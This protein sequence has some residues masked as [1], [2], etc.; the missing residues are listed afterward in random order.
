MN[1][2]TLKD[3]QISIQVFSNWKPGHIYTEGQIDL[4]TGTILETE[5]G[6]LE[7]RGVGV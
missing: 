5:N 3:K 4:L 2:K 1:T 6:N 7:W